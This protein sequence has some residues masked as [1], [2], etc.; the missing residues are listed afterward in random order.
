MLC[1][2]H[3]FSK[4]VDKI[5]TVVGQ[6]TFLLVTMLNSIVVL[7]MTQTRLY[8]RKTVLNIIFYTII[9]FY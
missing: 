8:I 6:S 7:N 5:S 3:H 1:G 4:E 2:C 9:I